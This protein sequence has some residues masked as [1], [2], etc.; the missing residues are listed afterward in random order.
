[1]LFFSHPLGSRVALRP[2]VWCQE[3]LL[4]KPSHGSSP[5]SLLDVLDPIQTTPEVQCLPRH[6]TAWLGPTTGQD[7][8]VWARICPQ[9][10]ALLG[11]LPPLALELEEAENRKGTSEE[12]GN[13]E[14]PDP[15]RKISLPSSERALLVG[16]PKRILD[17]AVELLQGHTSLRERKPA[18][19]ATK[20]HCGLSE[21]RPFKDYWDIAHPKN[22]QSG[23]CGL[24]QTRSLGSF[25]APRNP[26][27][28]GVGWEAR[29]RFYLLECLTSRCSSTL[30]VVVWL[31][32]RQGANKA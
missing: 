19:R 25:S 18:H 17:I 20:Q 15:S 2:S 14:L 12:M 26:G 11:G 13:H 4:G 3:P 6:P 8:P 28:I 5:S 30:T 29:S 21:P 23:P 31:L 22:T 24:T 1:L 32:G 27:R 10:R 16:G 9:E 7:P